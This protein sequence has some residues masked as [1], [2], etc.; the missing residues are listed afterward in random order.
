LLT[1]SSGTTLVT[2]VDPIVNQREP[3]SSELDHAIRRALHVISDGSFGTGRHID[4]VLDTKRCSVGE[5]VN[6]WR[7]TDIDN[8]EVRSGHVYSRDLGGKARVPP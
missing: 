8:T 7:A 3:L 5:R 1:P 6:L 2:L 4:A